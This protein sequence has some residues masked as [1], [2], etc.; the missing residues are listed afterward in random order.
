MRTVRQECLDHLLVLSRGDLESALDEYL[1]HYN[2][3]RPHRGLELA[4]PIQTMTRML[5]KLSTRRYAVGLEPVG[6]AVEAKSRST[7][8]S[9]VSRRFVAATE[10]ALTELMSVDLSQLDLVAIMVDGVNFAQTAT[11]QTWSSLVGIV[12]ASV[13]PTTRQAPCGWA[14]TQRL[15]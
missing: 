15:R 2:E 14:P 7:S 1:R 9:A 6:E 3:K 4:Q 10:S 11:S 5:A 12:M 8:K 13:P